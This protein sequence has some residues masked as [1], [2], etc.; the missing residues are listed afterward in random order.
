[1]QWDYFK[2][3]TIHLFQDFSRNECEETEPITVLYD[4]GF[5]LSSWSKKI[6]LKRILD[7]QMYEFF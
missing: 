4:Q 2:L 1:M 6:P 7:K 5:F 3:L